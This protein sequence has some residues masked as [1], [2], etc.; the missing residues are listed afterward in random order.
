MTTLSIGSRGDAVRLLQRELKAA[1]FDPGSVDGQY[2][3]GTANAVRAYQR[4]HGLSVDGKAGTNTM[5]ALQTD[6]FEVAGGGAVTT[7]ASSGNPANHTA[8]FD[9]VTG[10]GTRGQMVSGRITVNGHT[11]QFNSGGSGNG[12]LPRGDYTVTPHLWSRN[13]PG[14]VVGG[15]GFSFALTNKYD[16]RVG[17]T[18]TQLR[19]HPDGGSA[20]THGCIG[21]VGNAATQR[22]FREDMRAEFARNGNSFTLHVG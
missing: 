13:T 5:R 4:A 21:I 16:S 18:R 22:Q 14:M 9:R 10:A 12:N 6:G 15:V 19:I 7:P 20:G 2:G 17:A 3:T 11:Y 8:T 1:G